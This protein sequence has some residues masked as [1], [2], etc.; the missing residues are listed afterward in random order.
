MDAHFSKQPEGR[1][2]KKAGLIFKDKSVR[3]YTAFCL[4]SLGAAIYL[5]RIGDTAAKFA[6]AGLTGAALAAAVLAVWKIC[7]FLTW[8][9]EEDLFFRGAGNYLAENQEHQERGKDVCG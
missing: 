8:R 4:I 3:R 7:V 9:V 1:K 2:R 6:A 5:W